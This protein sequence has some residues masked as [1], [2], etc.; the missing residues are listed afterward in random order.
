MKS[1]RLSPLTISW[2]IK[3]FTNVLKALAVLLLL[4]SC[5][6]ADDE[7]LE[8]CRGYP[9]YDKGKCYQSM[10]R[11]YDIERGCRLGTE[12]VNCLEDATLANVITDQYVYSIMMRAGDDKH[13]WLFDSL[14]PVDNN[15]STDTKPWCSNILQVQINDCR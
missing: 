4:N 6:D 1:R 2:Y 8:A 11:K 5:N 3:M 9:C 12:E 15:W 10:A 14:I 7:R 13:C